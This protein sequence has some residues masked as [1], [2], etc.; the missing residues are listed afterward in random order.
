MLAECYGFSGFVLALADSDGAVLVG[1][2]VVEI[3]RFRRRS[4]VSLPFTDSLDLLTAS[5]EF[6]REYLNRLDD[7]RVRAGVHALGF[8]T[9]LGGAG[10]T[11]VAGVSH[12]LTL[13]SDT[14][15]LWRGFEKSRVRSEIR[16][17]EREGVTVELNDGPHGMR[18]FY[19]LHLQTRHRQ[20][21]PVQPRRF[22]DLLQSRMIERGL[23]RVV[24]AVVQGKPAAAA[25]VLAWN[26]HTIYKLAASDR[27]LLRYKPNHALVWEAIRSSAT[28]GDGVFDFGRSD[29]SNTGLR[30]FKSGW[31]AVETPL[32]YTTFGAAANRRD[33]SRAQRALGAVI[34]HSPP[35]VCRVLGEALYRYAA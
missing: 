25:I 23:G 35:F 10:S 24:V 29:L 9:G 11:V 31:G 6:T 5:Q 3:A 4:W 34:Q 21:V 19:D 27:H 7:L 12:E 26:R 13:T 8:R 16:R 2:P 1:A 18:V 15:R 33:A 22:F 28:A 20:G 32:E 30:A 17:S 14:D